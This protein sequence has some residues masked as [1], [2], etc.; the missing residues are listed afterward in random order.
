VGQTLTQLDKQNYGAELSIEYPISTTLKS[1]LAAA[2]GRYTYA[3]NPNVTITNDAQASIDN[4]N[5]VFDFGKPFS[6][7]TIKL[8]YP[9]RPIVRD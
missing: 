3:S 5:P 7:I 1:T 2:Y 9:N 8:V 4:S 6:K